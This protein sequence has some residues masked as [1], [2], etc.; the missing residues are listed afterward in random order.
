M[1]YDQNDFHRL[2][3]E[4]AVTRT[5][6]RHQYHFGSKYPIIYG[7]NV[8][9]VASA[10]KSSVRPAPGIL[11]GGDRY[12]KVK[13]LLTKLLHQI[14]T[15]LSSRACGYVQVGNR[16]GPCPPLPYLPR[17][18]LGHTQPIRP[19][20]RPLPV[21]Q[22][23]IDSKTKQNKTTKIQ[24]IFKGVFIRSG[25]RKYTLRHT[26]APNLPV[27][28]IVGCVPGTKHVLGYVPGYLTWLF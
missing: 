2:H 8:I 6:T 11:L 1:I 12:F 18:L 24:N 14:Y 15:S 13:M 10:T 26:R 19:P 3:A 5:A 7:Q 25:Y 9:I 4:R 22:K 23:Q 21:T 16:G 27:L 17:T 20:A 28:V